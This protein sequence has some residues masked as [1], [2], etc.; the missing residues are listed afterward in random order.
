[1]EKNPRIPRHF[2]KLR[3]AKMQTIIHPFSIIPIHRVHKNRALIIQTTFHEQKAYH[4]HPLEQE[5]ID[6]N[7]SH[8]IP[9]NKILHPSVQHSRY[10]IDIEYRNTN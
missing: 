5:S 4:A 9:N 8:M 3:K 7:Q 6:P 1:M 10:I 2:I